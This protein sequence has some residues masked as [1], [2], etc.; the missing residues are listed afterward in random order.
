MKIAKLM[1][2][3][4]AVFMVAGGVFAAGV[5]EVIDLPDPN[6]NPVN[7]ARALALK[8]PGYYS[9]RMWCDMLISGSFQEMEMGFIMQ[10]DFSITSLTVDGDPINL[11]EPILS[12]PLGD[13]GLMRNVY[14]NIS[15]M[16]AE[17]EYAGSGYADERVVTKDDRLS[18][19]IAPADIRQEIPVDVSL[20]GNDIQLIIED[21]IYGYGYGVSDGR[22][23]VYLPPVGGAYH[24]I[25]RRWSDG[26]VIGTGWLEPFKPVITPNDAYLGVTYLGNVQE[27]TFTRS[28]GYDDWAYLRQIK[29][30]CLVPTT[31]G[32]MMGKVAFADVGSSGLEIIISGKYWIYVQSAMD[33][34]G[35]MPYIPL[36]D[37]SQSGQGWYETRVNTFG[38]GIGKVVISIIPAPGNTRL[39]PWADFHKFY[40]SPTSGTSVEVVAE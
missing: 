28:E 7:V 17:G 25:L 29:F 21:F 39:N 27:V 20:Y 6:V 22:F 9:G 37:N 31:A 36:K 4:M 15:A 26:S 30:D 40:A 34:N 10:K 5:S 8:T 11:P 19:V 35:D 24:Y 1:A 12:L 23:Y 32:S 3:V 38:T 33:E 13:G 18:V 14:L 16:T 2:V